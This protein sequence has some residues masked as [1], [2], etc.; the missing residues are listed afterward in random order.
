MH[1]EVWTRSDERDARRAELELARLDRDL[2][3]LW[4][5]WGRPQ[6]TLKLPGVELET[7]EYLDR[8]IRPCAVCSRDSHPTPLQRLRIKGA[9]DAAAAVCFT[10]ARQIDVALAAAE[11]AAV[12]QL[13]LDIGTSLSKWLTDYPI[14]RVR[15]V[16]A[17]EDRALGLERLLA[18]AQKSLRDLNAEGV[19]DPEKWAERW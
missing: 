18:A 15:D 9:T 6:P 16:Q 14:D 1:T 17:S 12:S 19:A 5:E 13:L 10:C 2:D 3:W 4:R 7:G 8:E 11:L